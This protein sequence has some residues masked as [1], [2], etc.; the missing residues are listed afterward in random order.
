MS[1]DCR[2]G[3]TLQYLETSQES[4][5]EEVTLNLCPLSPVCLSAALWDFALSSTEDREIRRSFPREDRDAAGCDQPQLPKPVRGRFRVLIPRNTARSRPAA[6]GS[7]RS[8]LP[9]WPGS[10][11][12][13]TSVFSPA[14][15]GREQSQDS[16]S[17]SWGPRA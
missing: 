1:P 10:F 4:E 9:Q 13:W 17:V 14:N 12:L 11:H 5:G 3:N 15:E 2:Q 8:A 7:A 16:W 6:P